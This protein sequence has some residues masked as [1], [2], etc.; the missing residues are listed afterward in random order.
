[1]VA[2]LIALTV[3]LVAT[4][5]LGRMSAAEETRADHEAFELSHEGEAFGH[6]LLKIHQAALIPAYVRR[7]T[8]GPL[9]DRLVRAGLTPD[10]E[11]IVKGHK[12]RRLQLTVAMALVVMVAG[13]LVPA[14][15]IDQW[16]GE[17]GS[18]AAIA[19]G[20]RE[21]VVL[22]YTGYLAADAGDFERAVVY[23]EEATERGYLGSLA[24]LTWALASLGRCTEAREAHFEMLASDLPFDDQALAGRWVAFCYQ[25]G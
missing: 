13:V 9:H 24:D 18:H 7:D 17:S 8:H 25:A 1:M 20:W 10:W 12:M 3:T 14:S 5:L 15:S 16:D 6:A 11:P 22:G 4:R 21:E 2:L 23:L 19:F